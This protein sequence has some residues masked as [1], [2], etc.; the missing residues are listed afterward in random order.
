MRRLL[1]IVAVGTAMA[2]A[3]PAV[4][5]IGIPS[6]LKSKKVSG[7]LVPAY[8]PMDTGSGTGDDENE[9]ANAAFLDTAVQR[10]NCKFTQGK[11]KSQT[12]KDTSISL[13]GVTCGGTPYTGNLCAHTKVLSTIMSEDLDK[14]NVS[15]PKTCDPDGMGVAPDVAGKI[16]F[17]TGA[18]SNLIVCTAGTCTG[19]LPTVTTDPCPAVDKVAELRRIEVFDSDDLGSITILGTPLEHCCGPN[20]TA[21]GNFAVTGAPCNTSTQ[22]VFAEI[23]TVVQGVVP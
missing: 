14:N 12:G 3:A 15:T 22:D 8:A 4:H 2:I 23:G 16:N 10:G 7:D 21:V 17:S 1:S 6:T 5:G 20:Q 11:F 13:K 9:G 18:I 19:T